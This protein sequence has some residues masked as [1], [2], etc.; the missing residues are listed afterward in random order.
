MAKFLFSY[1]TPKGYQGGQPD[2]ME[3][4]GAWFQELGS[5]VLEPGNP[6]FESTAVGNTGGDTR[7]GGY[8]VIEADDLESAATLAKGCPTL[9]RG[10]GVDVGLITEIM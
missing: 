9:T 4:W 10:G 1:R 3:A 5:A 7:V 8:S 2:A 6:T